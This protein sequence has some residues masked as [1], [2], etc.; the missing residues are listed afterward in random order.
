MSGVRTVRSDLRTRL[1]R[2]RFHNLRRT[3]ATIIHSSNVS[4]ETVLEMLNHAHFSEAMDTCSHV[5]P[6]MQEI[7]VDAIKRTS[8]WQIRE[9]QVGI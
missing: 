1:L 5:L 4:Y 9:R 7:A 3:C 6:S 8:P 2:I